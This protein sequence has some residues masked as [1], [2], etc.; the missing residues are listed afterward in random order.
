MTKT[1]VE[2][3]SPAPNRNLSPPSFPGNP[4]GPAQLGV[5]WN[6]SSARI[7]PADGGPR[8]DGDSPEIS[9]GSQNART[10]LPLPRRRTSLRYQARIIPLSSYWPRGIGI[11]SLASQEQGMGEWSFGGCWERSSWIRVLQGQHRFDAGR[12]GLVADLNSLLE[13]II[14]NMDVQI[15]TRTL[16]LPYSSIS[17]S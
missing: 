11:R 15:I 2:K 17:I 14:D 4:L 7:Q 12:I 6:F 5:S 9:Q 8:K 3:F 16:P 1:V 13:M 10:H